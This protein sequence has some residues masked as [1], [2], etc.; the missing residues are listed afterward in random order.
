MK[1]TIN[2]I[3]ISL[4]FITFIFSSI[5]YSEDAISDIVSNEKTEKIREFFNSESAKTSINNI[6][7]GGE[8]LM[9]F[10][11]ANNPNSEVIHLLASLGAGVNSKDE[12]GLTPLMFAVTTN[13]NPGV[14]FALLQLG[15]N[16]NAVDSEGISVLMYAARDAEPLIIETMLSKNF[17]VNEP[18]LSGWTPIMFAV[19]CNNST[20]AA[21]LLLEAGAEVNILNTD[22]MSPLMIA[23]KHTNNPEIVELLL[24][25]SADVTI[26]TK[27]KMAIDFAN[28]NPKLKGSSALRNLRT[29]TNL[30][31]SE[32]VK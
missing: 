6:Y 1:N 4:I 17:D 22:G 18:A 10:A 13:K 29:V 7:P 28:N 23:A 26:I 11:A 14:T 25:H 32:K 9:M 31:I 16:P 30:R 19:A 27:G 20:R 2:N 5:S 21:E 24:R 3:L 8:T 12:L 15:A